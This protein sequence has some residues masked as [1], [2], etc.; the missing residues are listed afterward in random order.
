MKTYLFRKVNTITMTSLGLAPKFPPNDLH[1][2]DSTRTV[3]LI[4]SHKSITDHLMAVPQLQLL[5]RFF[6]TRSTLRYI[7]I[8]TLSNDIDIT[9]L[10]INTSK[11]QDVVA[12]QYGL[13]MIFCRLSD[14]Y[15]FNHF[16]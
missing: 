8:Y 10:P 14:I 7:K 6:L 12:V 3:S 11:F 16:F 13:T 4:P 1:S 9:I 5:T 15:L 2:D